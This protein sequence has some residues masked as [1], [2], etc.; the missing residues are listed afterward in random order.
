MVNRQ[1]DDDLVATIRVVHQAQLQ[2]HHH[3]RE[4]TLM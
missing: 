2:R 3:H 1:P 4:L